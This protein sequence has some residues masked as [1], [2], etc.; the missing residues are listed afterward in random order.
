MDKPST[1]RRVPTLILALLP[2]VLLGAL[3]VVFF[4]TDPT[5]PLKTAFPPIED[6]S[7]PQVGDEY[8]VMRIGGKMAIDATKPATWRSAERQKFARVDP[9]GKGDPAIRK[10]LEQVRQER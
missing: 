3:V 8:T 6:L 4:A 5:R 9:M 10:I 7:I 2:L 1:S